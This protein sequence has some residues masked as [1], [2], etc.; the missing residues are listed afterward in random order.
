M[1][2]WIICAVTGI[3]V[4]NAIIL[5]VYFMRRKNKGKS[6][7]NSSSQQK[8]K[9]TTNNTNDITVS[10]KEKNSNSNKNNDKSN[11]SNVKPQETNDNN[12][13]NKETEKKTPPVRRVAPKKKEIPRPPPAPP[14]PKDKPIKP[15]DELRL[16]ANKAFKYHD[17]REA[18]ALYNEAIKLDDQNAILYANRSA[19]YNGLNLFHAGLADAEKAVELDPTYIKGYIRLGNAYEGN[20]RWSFALEAY[21]KALSL[22]PDDYAI[23]KKIQ[24]LQTRI[25]NPDSLEAL[26]GPET[27][28]KIHMSPLLHDNYGNPVFINM[29]KE[30]MNDSHAMSKYTGQPLYEE[31]MKV[32]MLT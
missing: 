9:K 27:A 25:E 32:F 28:K 7:D 1:E 17:Y 18:V 23:K 24:E 2:T 12:N 10:D 15:V 26:V 21:E 4:L 5:I 3:V 29:L 30:I 14:L 20:L 19:A 11:E 31:F 8:S 13:N 22:A 6:K 16:K